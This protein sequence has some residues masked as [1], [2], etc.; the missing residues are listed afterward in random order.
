MLKNVFFPFGRRS[1]RPLCQGAGGDVAQTAERD[2]QGQRERQRVIRTRIVSTR[3]TSSGVRRCPSRS[4]SHLNEQKL[5]DTK[6]KFS[7]FFHNRR[8]R[9]FNCY[10]LISQ[11]QY[12]LT[13]WVHFVFFFSPFSFVSFYIKENCKRPFNVFFSLFFL[14]LFSI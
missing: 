13:F 3:I 7:F 14:S 11:Y 4:T 9:L 1:G 8:R 2:K 6:R 10:V 12:L 5:V